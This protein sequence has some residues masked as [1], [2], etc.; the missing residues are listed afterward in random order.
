MKTGDVRRLASTHTLT[1]T[2]VE[3][4]HVSLGQAHPHPCILSEQ[5]PPAPQMCFSNAPSPTLS[6]FEAFASMRT[7]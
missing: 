6:K 4:P 1:Y 2:R 5:I 7:N 3:E